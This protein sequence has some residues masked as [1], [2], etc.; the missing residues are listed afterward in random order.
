METGE[1]SE[2]RT[3]HGILRPGDTLATQRN[4]DNDPLIRHRKEVRQNIR[5]QVGLAL[6]ELETR[7]R[8]LDDKDPTKK[9]ALDTLGRIQDVKKAN[10]NASYFE[11]INK[12][13]DRYED[14]PNARDMAVVNVLIHAREI[15]TTSAKNEG[16]FKKTKDL[17]DEAEKIK[18]PVQMQREVESIV[19]RANELDAEATKSNSRNADDVP[20]YD[21][22]GAVKEYARVAKL[23]LDL[24]DLIAE[25][26]YY[27]Q[28][29]KEKTELAKK[30]ERQ[31]DLYGWGTPPLTLV[32]QAKERRKKEE[33][34]PQSKEES[35]QTGAEILASGG[36]YL[37]NT[38]PLKEEDEEKLYNSEKALLEKEMEKWI[39][40]IVVSA[41]EN[42]FV[43]GDYGVRRNV[44]QGLAAMEEY[45]TGIREREKEKLKEGSKMPERMEVFTNR[46]EML[47]R[48]MKA[49]YYEVLV[50]SNYMGNFF[51]DGME[52]LKSTIRVGSRQ[53]PQ[54]A[55][56]DSGVD[57]E[58]LFKGLTP[59]YAKDLGEAEGRTI[60]V[61]NKREWKLGE[62]ITRKQDEINRFLRAIAAVNRHKGRNG[63]VDITPQL[64][65]GKDSEEVTD[66]K[67]N[68]KI[69]TFIEGVFYVDEK[70]TIRTIHSV[71]EGEEAQKEL[72]KFFEEQELRKEEHRRKTINVVSGRRYEITA[73]LVKDLSNIGKW[74][75]YSIWIDGAKWLIPAKSKDQIEA[76]QKE[77]DWRV[78]SGDT[79]FIGT[80]QVLDKKNYERELKRA[81]KGGNKVAILRE[82]PLE[83]DNPFVKDRTGDRIKLM[84]QKQSWIMNHPP[85]EVKILDSNGNV[86]RTEKMNLW[87]SLDTDT[88]TDI[89]KNNKGE[90]ER[91]TRR[92]WVDAEAL[93]E[94]FNKSYK[95]HQKIGQIDRHIMDMA[96]LGILGRAEGNEVGWGFEYEVKKVKVGGKDVEVY[97]RKVEEGGT[98][99]KTDA[100][101]PANI[102][103]TKAKDIYKGWPGGM[104]PI[105]IREAKWITHHEPGW[106]PNWNKEKKS[107][108]MYYFGIWIPYEIPA[109][110]NLNLWNSAKV[111]DPE[112][113]KETSL[114]K[115]M[116]EGKKMSELPLSKAH[117]DAM[118]GKGLIGWSQIWFAIDQLKTGVS[119]D[120][121]SFHGDF[122]T[123]F[124]NPTMA[125]YTNAQKKY[126]LGFR[127]FGAGED[128]VGKMI[129]HLSAMTLAYRLGLLPTS[130][131]IHDR[132][133]EGWKRDRIIKNTA[134]SLINVVSEGE[135]GN[136][137]VRGQKF[138][139]Q[140]E[141]FKEEGDYVQRASRWAIDTGIPLEKFQEQDERRNLGLDSKEYRKIKKEGS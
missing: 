98:K 130:E 96:R 61:E 97:K 113:P 39:R 85:V 26:K 36:E 45:Y 129:S 136:A 21:H 70:K 38:E 101:T 17:L 34:R 122:G 100:D 16:I 18:D 103:R 141:K 24:A 29:T 86:V 35:K 51:W 4:Y 91:V 104:M 89:I 105:S 11:I 135:L 94:E 128:D 62:E 69:I 52:G 79:V 50:N 99:E 25:G 76:L 14:M 132:P 120:T 125:R 33:T 121:E 118:Y 114:Y 58:T 44:E 127:T 42:K 2:T 83:L 6:D 48:W 110:F 109:K 117:K 92:V 3:P 72:K 23:N 66:Y 59:K 41:N 32:D 124:E 43:I 22:E 15:I 68:E 56:F 95:N 116:V 54:M 131:N 55:S 137:E 19:K 88:V 84:T 67:I 74:G 133:V 80:E 49:N 138:L 112:K 31:I 90:E 107:W 10:P 111:D 81:D 30:L 46:L 20:Y 7:Y 28:G 57:M 65:W 77:L 27:I 5:A 75:D 9:D 60:Q 139:V 63:G 82:T 13:L 108:G 87:E 40:E 102:L 71:S 134:Q 53:D 93:A 8:D 1:S 106:R 73:S 37:P 115:L 119:K 123:N 64:R 47:T 78:G 12:E 126:T 140:M